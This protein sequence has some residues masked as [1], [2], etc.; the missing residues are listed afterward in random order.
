MKVDNKTAKPVRKP[1]TYWI[2]MNDE[3]ECNI[4]LLL[5]LCCGT[6]LLDQSDAGTPSCFQSDYLSSE[7]Y[8]Q[9]VCDSR[10][11]LDR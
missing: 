4:P 6:V 2:N 1:V 9:I 7:I 8:C 5:P 11:G 3:A 10:R